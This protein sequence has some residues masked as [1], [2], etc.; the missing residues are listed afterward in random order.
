MLFLILWKADPKVIPKGFKWYDVPKGIK[1]I[2]EY[3]TPDGLF[4]QI[5]EASDG[6]LL[7]KYVTKAFELQ[8][9]TGVEVHPVITVEKYK[10]VFG[11]KSE[12]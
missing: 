8:N 3:A 4:A 10:E 2:S 1:H 9:I 5:I 11:K 12:A 6:E 7:F